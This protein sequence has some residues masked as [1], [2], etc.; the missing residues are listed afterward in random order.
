VSKRS[1]WSI[2]LV[3]AAGCGGQSSSAPPSI[4]QSP[5][6]VAASACDTVTLVVSA[7]GTAS[8]AYQWL[9]NGSPISGATDAVLVLQTVDVA[10]AGSYSVTVTNAQGTV[11]STPSLVTVTIPP[12]SASPTVVANESGSLIIHDGFVVWG[13]GGYLHSTPARCPGVINHLLEVSFIAPA[14]LLPDGDGSIVWMDGNSGSQGIFST[15]LLN[16]QSVPLEQTRNDFGG[17]AIVNGRLIWTNRTGK[18]IQSMPLG[19]GIVDTISVSYEGTFDGPLSMAADADFVYWEQLIGD[20]LATS[21]SV[22]NRMPLGGGPIVQLAADQGSISRMSSDGTELFWVCT[23]GSGVN[24][25]AFL[26]KIGR[27]G[28][29]VQ[30]IGQQQTASGIALLLDGDSIFWT[31]GPAGTGGIFAGTGK[32]YKVPK[33]GSAPPTLIQDNLAFPD[34]IAVDGPYL[35]WSED[36]IEGGLSRIMR[37]LKP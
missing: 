16:G 8:I 21:T 34:S 3:F 11:A 32:L 26:R 14:N 22:I 4:L 18:A 35:Y 10:D 37:M 5:A 20:S 19:G 1:C 31:V 2:A 7:T 17:M 12:P 15:S 29:D 27:D 33:D 23:T 28:S 9:K 24:Q 13:G 25:T 36:G 30:T 6:S